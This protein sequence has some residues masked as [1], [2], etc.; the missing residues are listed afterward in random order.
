MNTNRHINFTGSIIVDGDGFNY[1]ADVGNKR[2]QRF[3]P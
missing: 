1:V 2:I 3:A